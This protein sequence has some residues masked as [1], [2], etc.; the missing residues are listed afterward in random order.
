MGVHPGDVFIHAGIEEIHALV[1]YG[2]LPPQQLNVLL[3]AVGVDGQRLFFDSQRLWG[4]ED[5]RAVG[6]HTVGRGAGDVHF[7]LETAGGGAP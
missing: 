2:E 3:D 7:A 5:D 6:G 1:G 4:V